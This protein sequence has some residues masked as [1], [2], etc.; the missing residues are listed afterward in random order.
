M[1]AGA[2]RKAQAEAGAARS[3]PALVPRAS[4]LAMGAAPMSKQTFIS[5]PMK[6][7][8]N[9]ESCEHQIGRMI[10]LVFDVAATALCALMVILILCS[11]TVRM[12]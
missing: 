5:P 9:L 6:F 12:V 4:G 11:I 8:V 7:L 1:Q 2:K 10:R 3:L